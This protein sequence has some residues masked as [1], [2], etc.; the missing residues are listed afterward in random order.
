MP[1]YNYTT[2]ENPLLAGFDGG[3]RAGDASNA[4][5]ANAD[6]SQQTLL[7]TSQHA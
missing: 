3:S 7:A 5:F 6:T 2:I 1:V 4:A